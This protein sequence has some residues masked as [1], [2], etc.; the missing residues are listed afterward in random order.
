MPYDRVHVHPF[1]R[2]WECGRLIETALLA[3]VLVAGYASHYRQKR[4]QA[5]GESCAKQ[6][7]NQSFDG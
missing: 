4:L 7:R 3:P 5:Y 6:R 1:M 2:C